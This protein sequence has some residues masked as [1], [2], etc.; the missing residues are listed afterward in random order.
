MN[1]SL[2]L[3]A[4]ACILVACSSDDRVADRT[5]TSKHITFAVSEQL[6]MT[7]AALSDACSRLSY[8][9][10]TDGEVI[11]ETH[12]QSADTDFGTVTD[13]MAYGTHELYFVGYNGTDAFSFD[14]NT[15]GEG[16]TYSFD[17]VGDTFTYYTSLTVDK[18][19]AATQTVTLPRRVA[20]FELVV[21]DALP[22]ALATM[23]VKI[24]GASVTLDAETGKGAA[25]A[26]QTKTITVPAANIGKTGCTFIAYA[27]LMEEPT[28]ATVTLTAK[29]ASGTTI[30]AYTL[31]DVEL[32]TNYITRYTGNFFAG[33]FSST[34]AVGTEWTGIKEGEF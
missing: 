22:A 24:E 11:T 25:A 31:T 18:T 15:D 10:C 26:V 4:A 2:I 23:E 16:Y 28:T 29:D 9:R 12:Q 8:F 30:Q 20:R 1:K 34:V 17:K 32:E 5:E 33:D 7:R 19:T 13:D 3:F 14:A 6:P 21:S 27:F